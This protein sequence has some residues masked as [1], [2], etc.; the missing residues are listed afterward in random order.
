[1]P[2]TYEIAAPLH[3]CQLYLLVNLSSIPD[4]GDISH[5]DRHV[6]D[7]EQTFGEAGGIWGAGVEAIGQ[8]LRSDC[9]FIFAE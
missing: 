5:A 4:F 8:V 6:A 3:L 7:Y 2:R 1:M 9:N